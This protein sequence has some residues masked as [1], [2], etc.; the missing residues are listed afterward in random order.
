MIP[1]CTEKNEKL[2]F[3]VYKF[4]V[5]L[6]TYFYIFIQGLDNVFQVSSEVIKQCTNDKI[7]KDALP[8]DCYTVFN[9]TLITQSLLVYGERM[10]YLNIEC[11][12]K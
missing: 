12:G 6:G 10:H 4:P 5:N 2:E 7:F 9:S 8:M 11:A 1:I 3:C